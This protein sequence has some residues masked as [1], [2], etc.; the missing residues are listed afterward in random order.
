M[1][2][3][4][5]PHGVTILA[6]LIII[7]GILTLL[8]GIGS[9]AIGPFITN[10]VLGLVVVV[11]GS[12]SLAL[13]VGDLVMAYGLWKGKAWAW[14]ISLFLLFIAIVLAMISVS[15]TSAGAFEVQT[16]S[17]ILGEIVA[18]IVTIGISTF[19]MY[20][21]YRPHVRAYFGKTIRM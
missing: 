7:A 12:I 2:K 3:Q 9:F 17:D 15:T 13:G 21:L 11:F 6:I 20:Y 16:R 10:P 5:R 19:I 14:T 4:S 8:A 1:R 18:S